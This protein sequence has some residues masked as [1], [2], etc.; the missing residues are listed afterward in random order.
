MAALLA[1]IKS[2]MLLPRAAAASEDS[3]EDP[4]LALIR[5]LQEYERFKTAAERLDA[6]PR[7]DRDV[8]HAQASRDALAAPPPPAPELEELLEALVGVLRRATLRSHHQISSEALSVR[9]R[10]ARI[11]QRLEHD[12]FVDFTSL[13]AVTEGRPGVV[14]SFLAVL[15]LSKAGLLDWGQGEPY[16]PIQVRRRHTGEGA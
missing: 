1:E 7:I 6:I 3:D 11:L 2:R 15:E 16:G 13:L 5:Q 4:R 9:E 14:V 8:F 10:M 12:A